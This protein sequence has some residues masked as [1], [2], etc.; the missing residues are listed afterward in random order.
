MGL[1]VICPM[2]R[3]TCILYVDACECTPGRGIPADAISEKVEYDISAD[4]GS[5]TLRYSEQGRK[6]LDAFGRNP[7]G[8]PA[9]GS[10]ESP[11]M[12]HIRSNL[13]V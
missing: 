5:W 13:W 4:F 7:L 2:P 8:K 6:T 9:M 3:K 11:F 10:C 12:K 1:N